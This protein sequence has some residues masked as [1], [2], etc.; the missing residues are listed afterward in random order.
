[1]QGLGS[2]ILSAQGFERST[3]RQNLRDF[4]LRVDRQGSRR[5]K[6]APLRLDSLDSRN[7]QKLA[8]EYRGA[9][10]YAPTSS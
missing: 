6:R 10:E 1:M 4:T 7:Q 9:I 5:A 2:A 8:V 3:K